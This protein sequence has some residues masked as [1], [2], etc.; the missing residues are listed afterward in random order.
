MKY[1]TTW[2]IVMHCLISASDGSC[3]Q[4][5]V[6]IIIYSH[7]ACKH[8]GY[9]M[10]VSLIYMYIILLSDALIYISRYINAVIRQF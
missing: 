6:C 2:G 1:S 9:S 4:Y 10:H 5:S 8:V 3:V 7:L